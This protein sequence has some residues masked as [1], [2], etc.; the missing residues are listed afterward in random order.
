M[1]VIKSVDSDC[2]LQQRLCNWAVQGLFLLTV[3]L[4]Q[5][6]SF[7][8]V[9]VMQVSAMICASS[10]AH[11]ATEADAARQPPQCS[12]CSEPSSQPTASHQPAIPDLTLPAA[13]DTL[14]EDMTH[15]T[16]CQ[17][18]SA[19]AD[20]HASWTEAWHGKVH[21]R[22]ER[23]RTISAAPD[24]ACPSSDDTA[25]P[26]SSMAE[27]QP[28]ACSQQELSGLA[29][30]QA[31]VSQPDSLAGKAISDQP[32]IAPAN[33]SELHR[34][35]LSFPTGSMAAMQEASQD[36]PGSAR[37]SAWMHADMLPGQL[38]H[39]ADIDSTRAGVAY[40][41]QLWPRLTKASTSRTPRWNSMA[42]DSFDDDMRLSA[43]QY[44]NAEG[45]KRAEE[46]DW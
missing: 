32:T 37:I 45:F 8:L 44:R 9:V 35:R 36:E 27:G 26:S 41:K 5:E 15:K 18:H 46:S 16:S 31:Q 7:I 29:M 33:S 40:T 20:Q 24:T 22:A 39:E 10:E 6:Q 3:F 19:A 13:G 12:T 11:A 34:I 2:S 23:C 42:S 14:L 17:S 30:Q 28:P 4:S 25:A 1:W 38:S 21:Q 43:L